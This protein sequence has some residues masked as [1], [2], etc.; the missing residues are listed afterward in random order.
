[1]GKPSRRPRWSPHP[2]QGAL[3]HG[4]PDQGGRAR[5]GAVGQQWDTGD[6]EPV[7]AGGVGPAELGQGL[8]GAGRAEA[9]AEV[10]PHHHADR[11]QRAQH[12]L[13][14]VLGAP[15]GD[16]GGEVDHH[17]V[18]GAGGPEQL[19]PTLQRR[20]QQR[21]LVGPDHVHRVRPEGDHHTVEV[22]DHHDGIARLA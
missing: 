9:E 17:D 15:P 5:L 22:A 16:L 18:R 12:G 1:M 21:G 6:R 13:D 19:D 4:V 3:G 8:H 10:L 20:E 14:E 2:A 7:P 11:V